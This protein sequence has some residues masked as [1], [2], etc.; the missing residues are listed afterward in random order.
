MMRLLRRLMGCKCKHV[1]DFEY[2]PKTI[3]GWGIVTCKGKDC[4][5]SD[6]Y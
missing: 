5:Y 1:H 4:D 6:L 2:H 3:G